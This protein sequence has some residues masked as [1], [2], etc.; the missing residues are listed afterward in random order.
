VLIEFLDSLSLPLTTLSAKNVFSREAKTKA[1]SAK[2]LSP[3]IKN[4]APLSANSEA[5]SAS[6]IG[7]TLRS[8]AKLTFKGRAKTI[9]S[10]CKATLS[11]ETI[12]ASPI[13]KKKV[14]KAKP[15]VSQQKQANIQFSR[16]SV[17]D[18]LDAGN[19]DLRDYLSNKRKLHSEETVHISPAQCRQVR[20]QPVKVHSVHCCL[21]PIPTTSPP[22]Q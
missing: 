14:L 15:R 3:E 20:C 1:L 17:L 21:G 7:R 12:L 13:A 16:V 10:S 18:Q 22:S 9:A 2:D 4:E 19:T 8:R 11:G 6:L 5:I